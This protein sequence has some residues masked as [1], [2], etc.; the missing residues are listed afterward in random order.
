MKQAFIEAKAWYVKLPWYWKIL[1]CIALVGLAILWVLSMLPQREGTEAGVDLT[2]VDAHQAERTDKAVA[3]LEEEAIEVE[4]VVQ[5][6]K[7]AIA[8]RISNANAIDREALD[9]REEVL[10]AETMEDLDALQDKWGL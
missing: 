1:G 4:R 3:E 7:K 5:L 9:R 6:R 2:H 10:A 8:A